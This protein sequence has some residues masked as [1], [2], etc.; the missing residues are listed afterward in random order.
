[1]SRYQV[2]KAIAHHREGRIPEAEA[3]YRAILR[4]QPQNSDALHL[5]GVLM[6]ERDRSNY[7][8]RQMVEAALAVRPDSPFI[9]HNYAAILSNLGRNREAARHYRLAVALKKDYVE[10]YFNL[11]TVHKFK[12]GDRE[13]QAM[14]KLVTKQRMNQQNKCFMGFALGKA[15]ADIGEHDLAIKWYAKGNA[16]RA[17]NYQSG[18]WR[19][20]I[21]HLIASTPR[22]FFLDRDGWGNPS[23]RPIF[24]VGM[25]RSGT[26]LTEQVISAHSNVTGG[27]ELND[28]LLIN[29]AMS[30]RVRAQIPC[31]DDLFAHLPHVPKEMFEGFA[32]AYLDGTARHMEPGTSHLVDKMPA[33]YANVGLIAL[34]FPNAKIVHITRNPIDTCVS[35]FFQKFTRGHDYAFKLEWLADH[36]RTY[37][38]LMAHWHRVLPGRIHDIAYEDLVSNPTETVSD[39]LYACGL[40]SEAACFSPH[41]NNRAVATASRWQVRQPIYRSSVER[42]RRYEAHI[43]PLLSLP[44]D[45]TALNETLHIGDDATVVKGRLPLRPH[46]AA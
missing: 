35:C 28:M 9:N 39:L 27:D 41:E 30:E 8:A 21:D 13:I 36:Y 15:F 33:N 46:S 32:G 44:A 11:A 43:G 6:W 40:D 42:W 3:T 24:V 16:N 2:Q 17:A 23:A 12:S 34:M 45:V 10:A 4:K 29:R 37:A 20:A 1:M 26:T 19:S 25:P 14:L 22:K 38:K 7:E 5:L 18:N 31:R